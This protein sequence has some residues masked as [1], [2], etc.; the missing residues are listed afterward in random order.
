M[1]NWTC[2]EYDTYKDLMTAVELIDTGTSVEMYQ[3][4]VNGRDVWVLKKAGA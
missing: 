3:F 1:A 4:K 2:T